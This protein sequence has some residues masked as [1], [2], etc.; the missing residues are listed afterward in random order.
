MGF[1]QAQGLRLAGYS[2]GAL[3][4]TCSMVLL[5][6]QQLGTPVLMPPVLAPQLIYLPPPWGDCKAITGDSEF[7]DTYSITACRIDCET[8]YLVENCNCRMVHMPG[9]PLRAGG[10]CRQ[11]QSNPAGPHSAKESHFGPG[12]HL[13]PLPK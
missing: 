9:E 4:G 1:S 10:E 7:F 5:C 12:Q 8:R 2:W 3:A 13:H 11:L 6:K